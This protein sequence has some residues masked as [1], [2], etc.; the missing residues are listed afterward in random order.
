MAF[1]SAGPQ[2]LEAYANAVSVEA[3]QSIGFCV[4]LQSGATTGLRLDIFR[5]GQ[6][7]FQDSQFGTE[8][9]QIYNGDYRNKIAVSSGQTAVKSI[10]FNAAVRTV[11]AGAAQSGCGWPVTVS[12]AVPSNAALDVYLGRFTRGT[13]ISWVAFVVRPAAANRGAFSKVLCQLSVNTYQAYNP[14]GGGC[15]YAPPVSNQ[16]LDQVSFDRPCQLWDYLLY[17]EPIV[18]WLAGN[19]PV[20]FCTNVDLNADDTLLDNYLLFISLG[21]DEYWSEEMRD[22]IELFGSKGGNVLFLGGNTIYR[23]VDLSS[24]A[25][26]MRRVKLPD[27]SVL[28]PSWDDFGRPEALTTGLQWSGGHWSSALPAPGVPYTVVAN[29]SHWVLAGTGLLTGSTF[30]STAQGGIIGYETDAAIL[31]GQGAPTAPTPSDFVPIAHAD[32]PGWTDN[33]PG[34]EATMGLFARDGGGVVVAAGTTGWGQ[35][36]AVNDPAVVR[37]TRNLTNVLRYP[38]GALVWF[39]DQSHTL[40][41]GQVQ[42]RVGWSRY[43]F[44]F[45]GADGVA[46]AIDGAGDLYRYPDHLAGGLLDPAGIQTI[47]RGGW[48]SFSTVFSGGAGVIYPVAADG[49]LKRY[50]DPMTGAEVAFSQN[51]TA[52]GWATGFG[53]IFSGG[54]GTI[55]AVDASGVLNVFSDPGS[56]ALVPKAVGRSGWSGFTAAFVGG[57]GSFYAV[58]QN[59][60]LNWFSDPAGTGAI[61]PAGGTIVGRS[62]WN[63]RPLLFSSGDGNV[64]AVTMPQ[65]AQT[66]TLPIV[67]ARFRPSRNASAAKPSLTEASQ[68]LSEVM[69]SDRAVEEA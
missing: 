35:G 25:R 63:T 57:A 23:R 18:G 37:L 31:D 69:M 27:A 56:G 43:L 36:L 3:G 44:A 11:P 66:P 20:E 64:Y 48:N 9:D 41:D 1:Q 12:W 2:P 19:L 45:S 26:I 61:N 55:Y 7:T 58:D 5:R 30:G 22:R 13:D 47:G 50:I 32:L 8:A 40:A 16:L 52:A 21:H 15:F 6:I 68:P 28:S 24:A 14:W 53:L 29:S 46:Y 62:G 33:G 51:I 59:G 17:D 10:T 60:D 42:D 49:T 38:S 4:A 54:G 67:A 39:K 34:A 65:P